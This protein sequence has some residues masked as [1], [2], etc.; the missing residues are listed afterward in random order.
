MASLIIQW[1][2]YSSIVVDFEKCF[3]NGTIA[4]ALS[5]ICYTVIAETEILKLSGIG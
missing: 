3:R 2:P 4:F 1:T 5:F